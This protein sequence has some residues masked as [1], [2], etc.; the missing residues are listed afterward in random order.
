MDNFTKILTAKLNEVC[1]D[2]QRAQV[3]QMRSQ[4]LGIVEGGDKE[5]DKVL[6]EWHFKPLPVRVENAADCTSQVYDMDR[7]TLLDE[8]I[9]NHIVRED[10]ELVEGCL[11]SVCS[12]DGYRSED[13]WRL[14]GAYK[15][16][17]PAWDPRVVSDL[18]LYYE[19]Q[20]NATLK[21]TWDED[22]PED[23]NWCPIDCGKVVAD[24]VVHRWRR[25]TADRPVVP[26]EEI[27]KHAPYYCVRSAVE[28]EE[29]NER[30]RAYLKRREKRTYEKH[31]AEAE[32]RELRKNYR[33]PQRVKPVQTQS[34]EDSDVF[35]KRHVR[36]MVQRV[37][38]EQRR[39]QERQQKPKLDRQ[40]AIAKARSLALCDKVHTQGNATL[41]AGALITGGL[42]V[43][44]NRIVRALR[45]ALD[46]LSGHVDDVAS[47]LNGQV[48]AVTSV[49][50][51]F[52]VT[53]K[54]HLSK[55]LGMR[56][57]IVPL[58]M[59]LFYVYRNRE[60]NFEKVLLILSALTPFLAPHLVDVVSEFFHKGDV[61]TQSGF[62]APSRLLSALMVASLFG[63]K[64]KDQVGEFMKR[65]SN[66]DR[67][68]SGLTTFMDWTLDAI[69]A[70]LNWTAKR[71]GKEA[72]QIRK[73]KYAELKA[74]V[75]K[76][77]QAEADSACASINL[78]SKLP[79]V[80]I[81]L[82]K[83]GQCFMEL[84]RADKT[85]NHH[86]TA[87]LVK[88]KKLLQPLA[89]GINARN[90]FRPEPIFVLL[91]GAPGVGKTL[92]TQYFC[93]RVLKESGILGEAPSVDEVL[94]NMWQKGSSEYFNGYIGQECLIMDDALQGKV[95][96]ADKENDYMHVIH[97]IGSWAYPLNFADLESKGKIYFSSKLVFGT[98][99]VQSV[100]S[101]A[102]K[103]IS[104]PEA[105]TRRIKY[106]YKLCLHSEYMD[107][108][109][110][111]DMVKFRAERK[112]CEKVGTGFPWYMWYCLKQDFYHGT[113]HTE[114]VSLEWLASTVSADLR[115]RN[116]VFQESLVDFKNYV[117]KVEVQGG[118]D[119]IAK[120]ALGSAVCGGVFV[121]L[122]DYL[123]TL[124]GTDK[125]ILRTVVPVVIKTFAKI[126]IGMAV[127]QTYKAMMSMFFGSKVQS[128]SNRPMTVAAKVDKNHVYLQSGTDD[129][130]NLA[131][132]NSF[133]MFVLCD[134]G[135]V[136]GMGQITVV[137]DN[138]AVMPFH[139][140]VDLAELRVAGRV[141]DTTV[142]RLVNV[143]NVSF[144]LTC[145]LASFLAFPRWS[146][147]E[148]DLDFVALKLTRAC[149]NITKSFI[150]D[151]DLRHVP[152]YA[153]RLDVCEVKTVDMQMDDSSRAV[154]FSPRVIVGSNLY[155]GR[156]HMTRYMEYDART[157]VGD[158][159]APLA[160]VDASS[161]Q[162][163]VMLGIHVAGASNGNK[164]YSAIVTQ[165]L[166]NAAREALRTVDDISLDDVG[167]ITQSGI[168][169]TQSDETPFTDMGSFLPIAVLSKGPTICPKSSFFKTEHF[170]AFGEYTHIPAIMSPVM[171][172]GKL[173]YPMEKAVKP[174]SSPV[175]YFEQEWI[176][177]VMYVAM[178]RLTSLTRSDPR[179]LYTFEE[180]V[181][182]IPERKFRSVPR[183]TAA[184]F[185]YT[186][187]VRNGKKEFF[188]YGDTYDLTNSECETLKARVAD[189]L[190]CAAK[191][192]RLLH[193][194]TDF[195]KDE[196]R[197]PEKVE[198]VSTRL[199][200]SSPLDY[201]LA[202]RM[203]FGAFSSSFMMR[204]T[205]SGM[206]PGICT[207]SEWHD[208][209]NV[210]H[211]HGEEVFAGDFKEFDSSEQP[212]IHDQILEYI[213]EWYSDGP[214]NALIRRVLWLE[215]TH[216][217]HVGG[218]GR[219]QR[220]MYQWAKSL[221]SGHPATTV[222]NS[223]YSLFCIV[224]AYY[225]TTGDLTGFWE[226]A[227]A[228]TY[229]D[230]NVV[231]A[232]V[233]G[234]RFNQSTVAKALAEEFGM[235]YTSDTKDGT[236]GTVTD[237]THVTF[238][239]RGFSFENGKVLC[240]LDFNSFLYTVY[241][242]KNRMEEKKIALSVLENTLEELSLHSQEVWDEKASEVYALLSK[243]TQPKARCSKKDYLRIVQSRTDSW[244]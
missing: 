106:G 165:E 52:I 216:S 12:T 155:N 186:Y 87:A 167:R 64:C 149:R 17:V 220:F 89:G 8:I 27:T 81:D 93:A 42:M 134:D 83:E 226:S 176:P 150:F 199:I 23:P 99:N 25:Q 130:A 242:C 190:A 124:E 153:V 78:S 175:L 228:V 205:H 58:L 115:A 129:I 193:V 61:Q 184:G 123:S 183:D 136:R 15:K 185:P 22:H 233:C 148:Y 236:L 163:R 69:Q 141:S 91:T 103:V 239:K 41:A 202:F 145:S 244:F 137:N 207:Y 113:T 92:I 192:Q 14:V 50:V 122:N 132:A 238:L 206:A 70:I 218:L 4:Y 166:I 188:G 232:G 241:W 152:G 231:G 127:W 201:M 235:V 200:S 9:L 143:K 126:A 225:K 88:V 154:H 217:R 187:F 97:A 227:S 162:G 142:V 16:M 198:S 139:Y 173:V 168:T 156:F 203:M 11:G 36:E 159:G 67:C 243:L 74:W 224:A 63:S 37:A 32:M 120:F 117:E 158:C 80:Y 21:Y 179:V 112:A 221:P 151:K 169:L 189:I 210:L 140:G 26:F 71:F 172:N 85:V 48:G 79:N 38:A 75:A 31:K 102:D 147:P 84:Y 35:S 82:Y 98:T 215:L 90:N 157:R 34:G 171:R 56:F 53:I 212:C 174:Y 44:G 116:E 3:K 107:E 46:R 204:H 57:W 86:I 125:M 133:K 40:R 211:K 59:A 108:A 54:K 160:M 19:R 2:I 77:E 223:M 121:P 49:A 109:G 43:T 214:V 20:L 161:F 100:Y 240:P 178:K 33:R 164:G 28:P 95:S 62:E 94:N 5:D 76:V 146:K 219:D 197:K 208:V 105:F 191:G 68:A 114:E 181:L 234:D 30:Q 18:W 194:F 128:Q 222:V 29:K 209:V 39:K 65:I 229:G 73:D 237:I 10:W 60:S 131:Y 177:H 45:G 182:G 51:D 144:V 13:I 101:E 119:L 72:V 47:N 1:V 196:L 7:V 213:N 110:R 135:G 118:K 55:V 96:V 180:A 66:M 138:L 104:C 24:S 195:L 170:G 230:D 6:G 111:L